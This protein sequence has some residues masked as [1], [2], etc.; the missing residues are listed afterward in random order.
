MEPAPQAPIAR[1]ALPVG[2]LQL[3]HVYTAYEMACPPSISIIA[4][5]ATTTTVITITVPAV[6]IP[7]DVITN[8]PDIAQCEAWNAL[9]AW[10]W[11]TPTQAKIV[12]LDIVCYGLMAVLAGV[13]SIIKLISEIMSSR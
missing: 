10:S 13:S 8:P 1:P 4:E 7:T 3:E 12:L 9:S 5:T 6:A 2:S 11:I